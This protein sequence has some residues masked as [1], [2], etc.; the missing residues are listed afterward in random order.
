MAHLLN[1][2]RQN[3]GEDPKGRKLPIQSGGMSM[4]IEGLQNGSVHR[5]LR[6]QETPPDSA[7]SLSVAQ[8]SGVVGA[9]PASRLSFCF[10]PRSLLELEGSVPDRG[11]KD[12]RSKSPEFRRNR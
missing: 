4:G 1:F 12:R 10:A 11:N 3:K 2:H 7:H 8:G 5:W 9:L 6:G